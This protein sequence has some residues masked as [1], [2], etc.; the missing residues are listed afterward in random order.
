MTTKERRFRNRSLKFAE[1]VIK[2]KVDLENEYIS[3]SPYELLGRQLREVLAYAYR[4]GI[5]AAH[6]GALKE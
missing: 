3:E 5:I 2:E 1:T 6:G 4:C